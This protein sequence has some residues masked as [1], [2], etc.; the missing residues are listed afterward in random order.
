L[1]FLSSD[2]ATGEPK[3]NQRIFLS[4]QRCTAYTSSYGGSIVAADGVAALSV[5]R[6]SRTESPVESLIQVLG[7]LLVLLLLFYPLALFPVAGWA[8][9]HLRRGLLGATTH[10]RR[11]LG[12]GFALFA[13]I[14]FG[15][16]FSAQGGYSAI[17][18]YLYIVCALVSSLLACL[19]LLAR[20]WRTPQRRN[21][22]AIML[23]V[24]LFIYGVVVAR[25]LFPEEVEA[26][27]VLRRF[28]YALSHYHTI[29]GKFPAEPYNDNV[30]AYYESD[31]ARE[32][33]YQCAKR[34]RDHWLYVINS[35]SYDVYVGSLYQRQGGNYALGAAYSPRKLPFF[36]PRV[37]QIDINGNIAC[38]F[39]N[40]G[41]FP[42]EPVPW[43]G[44]WY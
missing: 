26:R 4:H 42:P 5:G 15:L 1:R 43:Q 17:V 37:C 7:V 18:N 16:F 24:P 13:A 25:D 11:A 40:W 3:K 8:A 19:W 36:G 31:P 41:V 34:W 38:G 2:S 6:S 28:E 32:L 27:C 9:G 12:V 14:A 35:S 22:I 30:Q 23:G 29:Y 20:L 33:Y 39:N 44:Q 10:P 21:A